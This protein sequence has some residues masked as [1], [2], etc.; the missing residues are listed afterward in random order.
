MELLNNTGGGNPSP[1][2]LNTM[3]KK[4][5][6]GGRR[7]GGGRKPIPPEQRR[8]VLSCR[9]KPE[10]FDAICREAGQGSIGR[11]LDKIFSKD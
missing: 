5:T 10:T 4:S 6:R 7:P 9:V 3:E 8:I 11:L 2:S 1:L